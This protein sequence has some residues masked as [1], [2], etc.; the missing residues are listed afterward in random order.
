MTNC[1]TIQIRTRQK[2]SP[3]DARVLAEYTK[4]HPEIATGVLI[5]KNIQNETRIILEG[6]GIDY[7]AGVGTD[8]E[9]IETSRI[10][11][12]KTISDK[13]HKAEKT[14]SETT[15]EETDDVDFTSKYEYSEKKEQKDV[16]CYK[17][18]SEDMV[19]IPNS[20]IKKRELLKMQTAVQ[21]DFDGDS[22]ETD[23]MISGYVSECTDEFYDEK[24]GIICEKTDALSSVNVD[25]SEITETPIQ[26]VVPS[27][28]SNIGYRVDVRIIHKRIRKELAEKLIQEVNSDKN[29]LLGIATYNGISKK[30]KRLMKKCNR[31]VFEESHPIQS[32]FEVR[33]MLYKKLHKLRD[34]LCTETAEMDDA[35]FVILYDSIDMDL[36]RL[37]DEFICKDF[38]FD[39]LKSSLHILTK[40]LI[41]CHLRLLH[42]VCEKSKAAIKRYFNLD[43]DLDEV[44]IDDITFSIESLGY[45]M[46][47]DFGNVE[48]LLDMHIIINGRGSFMVTR[49]LKTDM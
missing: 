21:Q 25:T 17:G 8:E 20:N 41:M 10:V 4:K 13:V 16:E 28:F 46:S 47:K 34:T 35:L 29:L 15:E 22:S 31:I 27:T 7:I 26:N 11:L 5:S 49:K 43:F 45:E 14:E 18:L 39:M 1:T 32:M 33:E 48:I 19:G 9:V 2:M 36:E 30:A 37:K 40:V 44:P 12:N 38:G 42:Q 6:A 3:S 24:P 23:D